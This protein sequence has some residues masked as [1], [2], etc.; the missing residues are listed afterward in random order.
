MDDKRTSISVLQRLAGGRDDPP[1]GTEA[2]AALAGGLAGL[3]VAGEGVERVAGVGDLARAVR[4]LGRAEQRG[5]D[6][7]AGL[8][9]AGGRQGWPV[10]CAVA[11]A[12]ALGAMIGVPEV[13][14]AAVGVDEERAQ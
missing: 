14:R 9:R 3:G 12:R 7:T 6:R 1:R 5:L 13:K 10:L 11:A 4:A 2:V 8:G